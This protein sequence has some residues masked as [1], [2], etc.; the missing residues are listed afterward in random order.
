MRMLAPA[1]FHQLQDFWVN[2]CLYLPR[3]LW[4]QV[5]VRHLEHDLYTL[6]IT[7]RIWVWV[8]ITAEDFI[9]ENT[10]GV[11]VW[12]LAEDLVLQEF[13]SHPWNSAQSLGLL[14]LIKIQR[15][16][17]K[18]TWW[19]YRELATRFGLSRIKLFWNSKVAKFDLNCALGVIYWE[20]ENI[21]W[22]DI[23]MIYVGLAV[24]VIQGLGYLNTCADFHLCWELSLWVEWADLA[25]FINQ[26]A[27]VSMLVCTQD[28]NY[29]WMR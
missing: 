19:W 5:V 1:G 6:H 2:S 28:L 17:F 7:I 24:Q 11:Y 25:E 12:L 3:D 23:S 22:F 9:E 4:P 8:Q 27:L 29:V 16:W 21:L 18:Y 14:E 20:N 13:W 15:F 10:K 26:I